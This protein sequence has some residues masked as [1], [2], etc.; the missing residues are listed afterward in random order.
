MLTLTYDEENEYHQ[1]G[2]CRQ[3]PQPIP[4][5]RRGIAPVTLFLQRDGPTPP[6]FEAGRCA[7][8]IHLQATAPAHGC[9]ALLRRLHSKAVDRTN[10]CLSVCM[11][12]DISIF[13]TYSEFLPYNHKLTLMK[14]GFGELSPSRS[15]PMLGHLSERFQL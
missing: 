15:S 1:K 11:V 7:W 10:Y 14:L 6:A 12:Q 2:R 8:E 4:S 5:G 13:V 3:V 9:G